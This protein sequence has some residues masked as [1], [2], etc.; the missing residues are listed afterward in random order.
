MDRPLA[1]M[2][3][4]GTEHNKALLVLEP[5]NVPRKVSQHTATM[6]CSVTYAICARQRDEDLFGRSQPGGGLDIE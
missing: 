1:L 5:R 2:A 6:S 3:G 4:D